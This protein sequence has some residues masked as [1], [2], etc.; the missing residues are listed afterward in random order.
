MAEL[1][2]YGG[3]SFKNT[4]GLLRYYYN[5]SDKIMTDKVIKMDEA[6]ITAEKGIKF[7]NELNFN[8]KKS[9]KNTIYNVSYIMNY[10]FE[11]PI[12]NP[13]AVTI[14]G[15]MPYFIYEQNST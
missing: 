14:G 1:F 10:I 12:G 7:I 9:S 3:H 5:S 11:R 6:I 8:I 13:L 15:P 4:F 2:S